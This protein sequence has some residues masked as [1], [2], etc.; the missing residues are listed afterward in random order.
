M[1]T[2]TSDFPTETQ[3]RR[4]VGFEVLTA[5]VMKSII[6]CDITPCRPL[7]VN[8]LH[9]VISQKIVLFKLC[10][11]TAGFS[12]PRDYVCLCINPTL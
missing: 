6:F 11:V 1:L 9:G 2:P 8:G 12:L 10:F 4:F 7:N 3:P 5:V